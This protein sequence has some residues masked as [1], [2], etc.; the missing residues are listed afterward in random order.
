MIEV[1]RDGPNSI[2]TP[3][4]AFAETVRELA[5]EQQIRPSLIAE[6]IQA[7]HHIAARQRWRE[8]S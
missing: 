4:T 7:E 3:W 1:L 8:L 5:A 6:Q 2:E